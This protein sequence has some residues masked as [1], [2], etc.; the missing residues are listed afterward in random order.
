MHVLHTDLSAPSKLV[1]VALVAHAGEGAATWVSVATLARETS[2]SVRR[3]RDAIRDLERRGT[4]VTESR[5][6]PEGGRASNLYR[7]LIGPAD[8]AAPPADAAGP[9]GTTC[10][11]PR[12][13]S[14]RPPHG[15]RSWNEINERHARAP[16][17]STIDPPTWWAETIESVAMATGVEIDPTAAWIRYAG[18]REAKGR[19]VSPADAR[20]WLITVDVREAREARERTSRTTPRVD[21]GAGSIDSGQS[22][23]LVPPPSGPRRPVADD[24]DHR[25]RPVRSATPPRTPTPRREPSAIGDVLVAPTGG[26]R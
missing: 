3:V 24:P 13:E 10:R 6:T 18:H 22:P 15:T 26:P 14:T 2:L 7:V 5:T 20:Q 12:Q 21:P 9:P 11:T 16:I 17:A 4:I 23:W 25:P 8:A 1:A 19:A